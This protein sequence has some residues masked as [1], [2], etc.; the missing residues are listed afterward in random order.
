MS[1]ASEK[2]QPVCHCTTSCLDR[3]SAPSQP[4]CMTGAVLD[5]SKSRE[6]VGV[7][8][9]TVASGDGRM[10][11]SRESSEQKAQ[12]L[13]FLLH[14]LVDQVMHFDADTW[15]GQ[16][17]VIWIPDRH[18]PPTGMTE[19][20]AAPSTDELSTNLSQ[21]STSSALRCRS[22]IEIVILSIL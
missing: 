9:F 18:G 19:A 2:A 3:F 1:R 22:V 8:F 13:H 11:T 7:S 5:E 4:R 21:T 6:F 14:Q 15:R 20:E 10:T 16:V 12:F 17:L